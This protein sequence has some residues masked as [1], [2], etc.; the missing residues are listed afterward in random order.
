MVTIGRV[1]GAKDCGESLA[2]GISI[3]NIRSVAG[4]AMRN[5]KNVY[6]LLLSWFWV[7]YYGYP[8]GKLTVVGVTG[9]D[10]KTTTCTLIYEILKA[11]GIRTGLLS[12]VS[13]DTGLHTTNPDA[14]LLQ[15][16]LRR[17]VD[18]G[19]THMVLEVTSHGLDQNRVVGCNFFI[20][21]LTNITHE[22]LDYHKTMEDYS[23]TKLK[24]FKMAKYAVL[25]KDDQSFQMFN[26]QCTKLNVKMVPYKMTDRKEISPALAGD[27]NR[28]NI[29]AAEAAAKIL[30]I[31]PEVVERIVKNFAGVPGRRE[32][33][34]MGQKFRVI[35]DFAHTPNALESV[36][37][38]L[39]KELTN[40]KK[41]IVVFGCTG[42]RDKTKR[43]I[44]GR[45]AE[46]LADRIVITS[47][48]TRGEEQDDIYDQI[49]AGIEKKGDIIK[50]NDRRK[51]IETAV[52]MAKPG[53][54][55]LLA[56]KGHEK[57]IL[58]GAT[59]YPWSDVEEAKKLL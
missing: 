2:G 59:E 22:H 7:I 50:E 11:A 5:I 9:T 3:G 25:N 27:Y 29:G 35:V 36:L 58:I 46:K 33:V 32:E 23:E 51:A 6:H 18:E 38:Q 40:G 19:V 49:A 4:A 41:L 54:I 26:D 10:G 53:D 55:V 48:D 1:G 17:M 24:L 16:I 13:A 15:Q 21:V 45:V 14:R 52:K 30:E 57:S 28:S 34:K 8:A 47:D 39:G 56:G 12:T 44:M 43:P 31:R 42:G 20:G 37:T